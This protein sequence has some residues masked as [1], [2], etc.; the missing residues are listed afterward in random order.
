MSDSD[1][2]EP[3]IPVN[4]RNFI[5][6]LWHGAFLALGVSLTQPTTVI[7]AFVAE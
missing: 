5:A 3:L 2:K 1:K 6:G 7:S 4:R